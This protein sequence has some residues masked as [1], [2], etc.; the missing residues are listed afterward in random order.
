MSC[1]IITFSWLDDGVRG[2]GVAGRLLIIL[3]ES[4]C[5][6]VGST[7]LIFRNPQKLPQHALILFSSNTATAGIGLG[8]CGSRN[9]LIIKRKRE[10]LC[11][12]P[13]Q[14]LIMNVNM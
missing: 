6:P 7:R 4:L 11:I 9:G 5:I 3:S 10:E 14:Y 8:G 1:N 12:C 2:W 13:Q